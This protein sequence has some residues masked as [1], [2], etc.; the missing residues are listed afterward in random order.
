MADCVIRY[1]GGKTRLSPWIIDHFPSHETYIEPFGGGGSVLINK[2]R[3]EVEVYNDRDGDV[4]QFFRVLRDCPEE[5]AEWCRQRPYAK[6][7]YE[8]YAGQFYSGYRPDDPVERAGRFYYLRTSQFAAKYASKS[9]FSTSK[10][11][12]V[13]DTFVRKVEGLEEFAERLRRVQIENRDYE[14]L[15]E[16]FDGPDV[17]WYC[18]PPYVEEG[19]DLY[20]GDAFDHERFCAALDALEGYWCVS[21]TDLPPQLNAETVVERDEHQAMRKGQDMQR[22]E[23]TERL[24]MNYDPDETPSFGGPY[25]DV[26]SWE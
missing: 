23:R 17:L 22:E 12:N 8:K 20:T 13:A 24:A 19:D 3:S 5:L 21:Y 15:F 9:G 10:K 6:D 11:R 2:P 1:P 14:E 18:D 26:T 16:R 25:S 4:V 7:L